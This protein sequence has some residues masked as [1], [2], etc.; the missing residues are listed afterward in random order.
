MGRSL[1]KG[2]F[3]QEKLLRKVQKAKES[4]ERK[5]IKT[6]SRASVIAPEFVGLTFAVHDG[7]KH[8]PD[9]VYGW[10]PSGRIRIDQNFPSAWRYK[11]KESS[12]KNIKL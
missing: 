3:I 7:K 2:P 1:T 8:V 9:G 10:P 11:S 6:W 4:G 5:P 12:R